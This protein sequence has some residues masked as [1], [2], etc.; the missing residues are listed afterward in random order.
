MD[1]RSFLQAT[2]I[3]T[4][5]SPALADRNESLSPDARVS[6]VLASGLD[7]DLKV[8][9]GPRGDC[10]SINDALAALSRSG[11]PTYVK[12]GFRAEIHLQSGFALSEQVVVDR[13]D[14]GWITIT[15][16]DDVVPIIGAS[17]TDAQYNLY[18]PAFTA[19]R[20][21]TLPVIHTLFEMDRTGRVGNSE[22][23]RNGIFVVD[24]SFAFIT[25]GSGVINA[26]GRGLH[27]ANA[28]SCVARGA[29]FSGA[30]VAAVRNA[31]SLVEVRGAN[32]RD[33]AIGLKLAGAGITDAN[34]ADVSGATAKGIENF[35]STLRFSNAFANKCQVA[36]ES[37]GGSI[38][39]VAAEF[40]DSAAHAVVLR[41]G[42]T[43]NFTSSKIRR[44]GD[45]ALY[46]SG[47]TVS[48]ANLVA[49][50]AGNVAVLGIGAIIAVPD[51]DLRNAGSYGIHATEGSHVT[52]QGSDATGAGTSGFLNADGS[53]INATNA[54][55]VAGRKINTLSRHGAIFRE[56][57]A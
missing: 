29:N 57:G 45:A 44:A 39:A 28:S 54:R 11:H 53:F 17:L 42:A 50:G 5:G 21:A 19:S 2:L 4:S 56:P 40:D 25:P 55:G 48:A 46:V 7:F 16:E 43:A 38:N 23:N 34:N 51:A 37:W 41:R 1:R 52:A 31:N 32:L 15:S 13:V 24:G 30:G 12:G 36:V 26:Q 33:S 9:V 49:A 18:F 47:S 8:T 20:G 6:H 35:E 14:L 10:P 3:A 22:A 27:V